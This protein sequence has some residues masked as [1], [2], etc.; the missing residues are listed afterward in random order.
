MVAITRR[1]YLRRS[2]QVP[3]LYA[4]SDS[5]KYRKAVMQNSCFNGMYFEAETPLQPKFDLFIKIQGHR[6]GSDVPVPYKAF[7]ARV[8]W[9]RQVRNDKVPCYGIGVQF[10]AKSHVSYGINRIN[11]CYLCDYCEDKSSRRLIHQTEDGLHFCPDCLHHMETLPR[12]IEA[13]VERFLL[14]NVV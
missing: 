5:K 1:R 10:T 7:R 8:K 9:C 6:S 2:C 11:S 4:G 12:S 3:I 14:G 13:A